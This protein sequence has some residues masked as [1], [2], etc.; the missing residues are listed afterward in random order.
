MPVLTSFTDSGKV[1]FGSFIQIDPGCRLKLEKGTCND[2]YESLRHD[3]KKHNC[4]VCCPRG[5]AVFFSMSPLGSRI[6]PWILTFMVRVS[7]LIAFVAVSGPFEGLDFCCWIRGM[8][9]RLPDRTLSR[10]RATFGIIGIGVS[11]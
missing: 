2:F 5:Y 4:F 1:E 7:F 8:L 10:K 9:P 11:I 3:S 6:Y